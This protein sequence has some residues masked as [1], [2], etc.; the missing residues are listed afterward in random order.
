[1][2][3]QA[4]QPRSLQRDTRP[5]PHR[6]TAGGLQRL[7]PK[8][9]RI[10]RTNSSGRTT[11]NLS[12]CCMSACATSAACPT[13]SDHTCTGTREYPSSE[14]GS[15]GIYSKAVTRLVVFLNVPVQSWN[16]PPI[17]GLVSPDGVFTK[18]IFPFRSL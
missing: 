6:G 16:L 5:S 8:F 11:S 2:Q 9:A 3:I 7:G 14:E 10:R 18:S 4:M 1:M 13:E 15:A 17:T 12:L